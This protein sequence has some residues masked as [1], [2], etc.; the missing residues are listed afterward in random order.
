MTAAH[1]LRPAT[2]LA[3]TVAMLRV[4]AQLSTTLSRETVADV[5][6]LAER[7]EYD[8]ERDWI[9]AAHDCI[10]RAERLLSD[11]TEETHS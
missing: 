11:P 4:Q 9:E 5:L 1:S 7:A 3:L 10:G 6:A 8:L 2:R